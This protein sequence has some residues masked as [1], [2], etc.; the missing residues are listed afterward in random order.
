M[1]AHSDS[2][3]FFCVVNSFDQ[4]IVKGNCD[5]SKPKRSMVIPREWIGEDQVLKV[6]KPVKFAIDSA[7]FERWMAMNQ[8]TK[9]GK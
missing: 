6:N 1:A 3:I 8:P 7:K 2:H 5:P 9:K 4:K